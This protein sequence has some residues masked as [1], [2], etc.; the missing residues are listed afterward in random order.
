MARCVHRKAISKSASCPRSVSPNDRHSVA[1]V[2]RFECKAVAP[3]GFDVL[4]LFEI[5]SVLAECDGV[6]V[7]VNLCKIVSICVNLCQCKAALGVGEAYRAA[8][9]RVV[10]SPPPLSRAKHLLG[11]AK[12]A[13]MTP[14]D[15]PKAGFNSPT[16][17]VA[18]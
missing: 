14:S 13:G 9:F 5:L 17:N 18:S 3:T 2:P 12:V 8:A 4:W 16:W 1:L 15:A 11:V 10:C 7:E 6:C